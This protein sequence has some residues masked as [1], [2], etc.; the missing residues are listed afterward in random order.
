MRNW[1]SLAYM[2]RVI[3][4]ALPEL[5]R[6]IM[7]NGVGSVMKGNIESFAMGMN[8]WRKSNLSDIRFLS[9]VIEMTLNSFNRRFMYDG[10]ISHSR[11]NLRLV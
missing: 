4:S 5:A 1:A 7:T 11:R 10:G 9:P 8:S 2:G 6:P 3:F